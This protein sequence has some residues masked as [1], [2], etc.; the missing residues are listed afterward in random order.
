MM[1][2]PLRWRAVPTKEGGDVCGSAAVELVQW[3]DGRKVVKQRGRPVAVRVG[4]RAERHEEGVRA[5][6]Q[7]RQVVVKGRRAHERR[8]LRS[9]EGKR[10]GEYRAQLAIR[11]RGHPFQ[12]AAHALH[13]VS[14][15]RNVPEPA[16]QPVGIALQHRFGGEERKVVPLDVP[17]KRRTPGPVW[18]PTRALRLRAGWRAAVVAPVP[19]VRAVEVAVC[20]TGR[21]AAA[22][23]RHRPAAD[24]AAAR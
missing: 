3:D 24:G 20:S 7:P 2:I 21:H 11:L 16:A 1:R 5:E 10:S 13:W 12:L 4:D 19:R 22:R 8:A 14:D 23:L 15:E 17:L 18:R 9:V 6:Q